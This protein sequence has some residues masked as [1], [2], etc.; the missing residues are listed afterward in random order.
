MHF[1][2]VRAGARCFTYGRIALLAFS[3][4]VT[5][6][7][8][9]SSGADTSGTDTQGVTSAPVPA[10]T[11]QSAAVQ[12]GTGGTQAAPASF[13][14][15]DLALPFGTAPFQFN[16]PAAGPSDAVTY[17]SSA[18]EVIQI[19]GNTVT[20][21]GAGVATVTATL[22]ATGQTTSA[23]VTVNK[24]S[25][26][27]RLAA[28][29]VRAAHYYSPVAL[30]VTTKSDGALTYEL[31]NVNVT[32]LQDPN[33]NDLAGF[34]AGQDG[35]TYLNPGQIPM[36][37]TITVKQAATANY[38]GA[39][40]SGPLVVEKGLTD[41]VI[42]DSYLHV[43]G[44]GQFDF[45]VLVTQ[46]PSTEGQVIQNRTVTATVTPPSFATVYYYSDP[47]SGG[48]MIA[49]RPI[50]SGTAT[51]TVSV[52]ETA[53]M[54]A[55]TKTFDLTVAQR[56]WPQQPAQLS[57]I[58]LIGTGSWRNYGVVDNPIVLYTCPDFSKQVTFSFAQ[59]SFPIISGDP[60]VNAQQV[61]V[62][63]SD[64]VSDYPLT[65]FW[66]HWTSTYD[67]SYKLSTF[68]TNYVLT[69]KVL[70]RSDPL[71]AVFYPA[72]ETTYRLQA[73]PRNDES[74]APSGYQ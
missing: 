61:S 27:L 11:G 66:N 48:T 28:T 30:P 18:P 53:N 10:G 64:G 43:T 34:F 3:V 36:T 63:L 33:L 60:D 54:A 31:S 26:Q 37:A 16:S 71:A 44:P 35:Q 39:T 45:P 24:A 52:S 9:G 32:G 23:T 2:N 46:D 29:T 6:C 17:T 47:S 73:I 40:V 56:I 22:V 72:V 13:T 25:P 69:A 4:L 20:V 70:S 58:T 21:V 8:G 41:V 49:F 68:P 62:T 42:A 59:S 55:V 38:E 1:I 19:S 65:A 15:G 12:S 51:L 5:A 14:F 50:M 57:N 67:Y 7:G 74:C